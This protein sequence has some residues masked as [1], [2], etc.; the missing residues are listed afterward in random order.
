MRWRL[1]DGSALTL[2]TS[3]GTATVGGFPAMPGRVLLAEAPGSER[4]AA[5]GELPPWSVVWF[6]GEPA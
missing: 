1:G 2:W 4:D 5:R 3:P 6:I